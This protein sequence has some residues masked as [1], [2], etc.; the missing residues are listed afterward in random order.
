MRWILLSVLFLAGA[1]AWLLF[2][3]VA[4]PQTSA[5]DAAATTIL[6][7]LGEQA[8]SVER[9]DGAL[10]ISGGEIIRVEGRQFSKEDSV[11]TPNS[12]RCTTREDAV[13]PY[14]DMHYTEM[15][16]G[17]IPAVRIHA[18]GVYATVRSAGDPRISAKT[19]QGAFAFALSEV[20]AAPKP[21]LGGRVT[22]VRAPTVE[23]LSGP[24]FEDDEPAMAIT[25]GGKPA[26]AWV[27]YRDRADR[28]LLR[29]LENGAWSEAEEVT[30]KTATIFRSALAADHSGSLWVFWSQLDGDRWQIWSR[31]RTGG[32][33]QPATPLTSQGSNTFLRA[34][35]APDGSI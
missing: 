5:V 20:T 1:L 34:A 7:T 27:A 35:A 29:T 4:V 22:V 13:A 32:A 30:P 28:V 16:P 6:I 10:A 26:V 25:E 12:W 17:S 9:W 33:W 2:R 19:A 23:K 11:T 8:K 24:Q 18:V 31:R 3:G 14:A 15:Q 21:F